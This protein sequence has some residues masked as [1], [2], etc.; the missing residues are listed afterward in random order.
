MG[1]VR[2]GAILVEYKFEFSWCLPRHVVTWDL[3]GLSC[4]I[5][6][7]AEL[8]CFSRALAFYRILH[9]KVVCLCQTC[10][11]NHRFVTSHEQIIQQLY[12]LGY[13]STKKI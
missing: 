6:E 1:H 3:K 9:T 4:V 10:E 8:A 13:A 12:V 5:G 11:Q 7:L 2:Y